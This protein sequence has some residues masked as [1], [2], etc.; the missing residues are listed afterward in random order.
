MAHGE[1]KKSLVVR[2]VCGVLA[3][4]MAASTVLYVIFAIIDGI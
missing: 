2:I 1:R 3:F 4:L